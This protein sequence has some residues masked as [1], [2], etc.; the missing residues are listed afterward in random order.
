VHR[1]F[2]D[3]GVHG[4]ESQ[5]IH[6]V[7][8]Q[9]HERVFDHETPHL[10][11]VEVDRIAPRVRALVAQVWSEAWEI[12]AAR[13]EVVVDHILDYPE[14]VSMARVDEPLVGGRPAIYL[15]DGI[16]QHPVVAPVVGSIEAVHRQELNEV[17]SDRHEVVEA[18]DGGVER[19]VRCERAEVQLVDDAARELTA[20]PGVVGPGEGGRVEG[21]REAVH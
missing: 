6:V 2:V 18:L 3:E 15:G 11:R 5:P 19:A 10:G 17:D 14:T 1:G 7:V 21:A 16:P 9:P 20:G 8:P 12:V 4:V 13:S